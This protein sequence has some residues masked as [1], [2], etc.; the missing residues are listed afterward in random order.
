MPAAGA[1]DELADAARVRLTGVVLW[2]EPLVVVIVPDEW[3][4]TPD[5]SSSFQI[6]AIL[7]LLPCSPELNTAWFQ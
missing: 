1:D 2:R 4:S 6:C 5:S 3:T 7:E